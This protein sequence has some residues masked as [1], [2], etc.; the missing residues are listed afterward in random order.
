[1]QEAAPQNKIFLHPG[2]TQPQS[3]AVAC[4]IV[5]IVRVV[6]ATITLTERLTKLIAGLLPPQRWA[7]Q[8][9]EETE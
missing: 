8:P 7:G 5:R 1:M 6:P 3:E 2:L 4:G 9:G